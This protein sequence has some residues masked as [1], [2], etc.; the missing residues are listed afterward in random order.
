M[1]ALLDSEEELEE[2]GAGLELTEAADEL[3]ADDVLA[4]HT[5]PVTCGTSGAALPLLP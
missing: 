2:T 1:A 4:P 3:V 5:A